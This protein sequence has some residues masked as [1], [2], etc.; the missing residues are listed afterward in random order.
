VPRYTR[1]EGQPLSAGEQAFYISFQI[2][3]KDGDG[4]INQAEAWRLLAYV[5]VSGNEVERWVLGGWQAKRGYRLV[6]Q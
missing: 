5:N 1:R 3:D 6:K 2:C 4:K